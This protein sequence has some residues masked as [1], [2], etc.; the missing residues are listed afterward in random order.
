MA[1]FS[2]SL[3]LHRP[4]E[5]NF[6]I[7][8]NWF[9][10]NFHIFL[11]LHRGFLFLPAFYFFASLWCFHRAHF[12]AFFQLFFLCLAILFYVSQRSE[13][14]NANIYSVCHFTTQWT[15]AQP[16]CRVLYE[17]AASACLKEF[18]IM[19]SCSLIECTVWSRRI[20]KRAV[21]WK[22]QS[23]LLNQFI[24]R[25]V[26]TYPGRKFASKWHSLKL[27]FDALSKPMSF[28]HFPL[29][30]SYSFREFTR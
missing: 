15:D 25:I 1:I 6:H 17:T 24:S 20:K 4:T 12:Y 5:F 21:E 28:E 26:K 9:A 13:K 18:T 3:A 27:N 29:Q 23:K 22:I 19:I 7:T 8:F 2:L 10:I 16:D 30:F 14:I 11:S